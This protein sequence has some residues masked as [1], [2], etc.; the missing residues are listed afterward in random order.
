MGIFGN[1][2]SNIEGKFEQQ[3]NKVDNF[4]LQTA[5]LFKAAADDTQRRETESKEY[6]QK[7]MTEAHDRFQESLQ[8]RDK[9]SQIMARDQ[10]ALTAQVSHLTVTVAELR[11]QLSAQADFAVDAIQQVRDEAAGEAANA[12]GHQRPRQFIPFLQLESDH[13]ETT[14]INEYTWPLFGHMRLLRRRSSKSHR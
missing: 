7:A 10:I 14:V 8:I 2:N 13:W 12:G 4:M 9:E 1:L 5:N 11:E 3:N 6:V